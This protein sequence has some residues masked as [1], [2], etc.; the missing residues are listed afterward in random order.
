MSLPYLGGFVISDYVQTTPIQLRV[1]KAMQKKNPFKKRESFEL[2]VLTSR[3]LACTTSD[4]K[5]K[6]TD[7]CIVTFVSCE[8]YATFAIVLSLIILERTKEYR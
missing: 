6:T 3:S 8:K 2:K 7:R 4:K 5:T 1:R